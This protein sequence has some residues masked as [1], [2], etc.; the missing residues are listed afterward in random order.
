MVFLGV[1]HKLFQTLT[2]CINSSAYIKTKK[3]AGNVHQKPP[4][5]VR[6]KPDCHIS[7]QT[8]RKRERDKQIYKINLKVCVL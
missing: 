8:T 1:P 2:N 5:I 6:Q 4:N 7:S 3:E